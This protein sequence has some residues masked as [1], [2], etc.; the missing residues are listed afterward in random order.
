MRQVRNGKR[1]VHQF[2]DLISLSLFFLFEGIRC[3]IVAGLMPIYSYERFERITHLT[4]VIIPEDL[5]RRLHPIK[6][7]EEAV[8]ELGITYLCEMMEK[9]LQSKTCLGF[10]FYTLNLEKSVTKIL[11]RLNLVPSPPTAKVEAAPVNIPMEPYMTG[12]KSEWDDFPNERWGDERSPA[13]GNLINEVWY[14]SLENTEIGKELIERSHLIKSEGDVF[15]IFVD[16]CEG[17]LA[18]LPWVPEQLSPGLSL[19]LSFS[20]SLSNYY[21]Y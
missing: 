20:L 11:H 18:S 1:R 6:G 16:F 9:I 17:K 14:S 19:S 2:F 21:Y 7:N 4:Q 15:Q 13:F 10:H 12:S 8:K 3:P 5:I